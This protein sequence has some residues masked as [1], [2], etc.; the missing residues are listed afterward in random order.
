[1]RSPSL[2]VATTV[3][4]LLLLAGCETGMDDMAEEGMTGDDMDGMEVMGTDADITVAAEARMASLPSEPL[5]WVGYHVAGADGV[6]GPYSWGPAFLHADDRTRVVEVDGA[7]VTLEPGE[8]VFL[9]EGVDH[10]VPDG[11]SW[12]FLLTDPGAAPP[13]GLEDADREFSSGPLQGLPDGDAGVRFLVVDLPP[14]GGQTAIHTHP[15]PEYIAVVEGELEYET[16]L[17][18]AT[19]LTVGAEAA[20]P[21]DTAVQKRNP[22]E[23]LSRFWSWFVV[24][25]DEPFAVE[26]TFD[27]Q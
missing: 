2:T 24:D 15:G 7:E 25:P 11:G 10:T 17:D 18:A 16:G 12:A 27:R 4:A 14:D 20:L 9:E 8:A 26:A 22:T 6:D 3:G 1:M 5:G 13:V 19:V 23:E 21:R